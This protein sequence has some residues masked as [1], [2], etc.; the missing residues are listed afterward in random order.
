KIARQIALKIQALRSNPDPQDSSQLKGYAPL[1]RADQ[2]EY[3]IIYR[4][5]GDTLYI[6]IVGK[7]ND[8]EVYKKLKRK[9]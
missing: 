7:R 9:K 3:R 8:G 1:K 5:D 4:V 2:G 6:E